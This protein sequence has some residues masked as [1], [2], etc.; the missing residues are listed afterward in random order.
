M[1]NGQKNKLLLVGIFLIG[2]GA[3]NLSAQ[4][5]EAGKYDS[6]NAIIAVMG[7]V[8]DFNSY[9]LVNLPEKEF[10]YEPKSIYTNNILSD[11]TEAFYGLAGQSIRTLTDLKNLQPIL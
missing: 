8:P 11:N 4:Q 3:T 5:E 6:E 7:F 10:W 2:L 1:I 9:R